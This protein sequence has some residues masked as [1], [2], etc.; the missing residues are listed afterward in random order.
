MALSAEK[1]LR[2]KDAGLIALFESEREIWAKAAR[3]AYD[4]TA[5]SVKQAGE[6]VRP[7][8]LVEVLV[9]VLQLTEVLREYLSENHLRQKFWYAF[10]AELIIDRMWS[11]LNQ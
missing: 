6:P 10:F 8:D 7:D 2:L 4:Y 11:E 9:P 5:E 3:E 1:S